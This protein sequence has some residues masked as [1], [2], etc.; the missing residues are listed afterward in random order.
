MPTPLS[1]LVITEETELSLEDLCRV[2]V[3]RS[4]QIVA[5]VDEGILQPRGPAPAA[6]RFRGIAL[7]RASRA[8]R[9]QR[10]LQLNLAGVALALDLLDEIEALRA[11]LR[12]LEARF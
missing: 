2:C 5:L 8:L 11:E 12:H 3:A 7:A 9:L 10:D 4:E 6:W 1:G